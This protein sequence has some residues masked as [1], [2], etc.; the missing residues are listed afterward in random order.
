M[1][2]PLV[3]NN[4][5]ENTIED[6]LTEVSDSTAAAA[7]VE[8]QILMLIESMKQSLSQAGRPKFK[9]FWDARIQCVDLLKMPMGL[10]VRQGYWNEVTTLSKEARNLKQFFDRDVSF[11][12]DQIQ[13]AFQALEEQVESLSSSDRRLSLIGEHAPQYLLMEKDFFE[14]LQ[15]KLQH[16]QG[17]LSQVQALRKEILAS[18][19][20][21]KTKTS[22]LDRSSRLLDTLF[23]MKRDWTGQISNKYQEVVERFLSLYPRDASLPKATHEIKEEIKFLQSLGKLISITPDTFLKIREVLSQKWDE[24][25]EVENDIRESIAQRKTQFKAFVEEFSKQINEF[26]AFC[27]SDEATTTLVD[28]KHK[29]LFDQMKTKEIDRDTF[30]SLKNQLSKAR[31]PFDQKI[32]KHLDEQ[33]QEAQ[34]ADAQV[35]QKFH[36]IKTSFEDLLLK[37]Q[38]LPLE[39]LQDSFEKTKAEFAKN[40]FT[41]FHSQVLDHLSFQLHDVIQNAKDQRLLSFS[42]EDREAHQQLTQLH[43]EKLKQRTELKKQLETSRKSL[44]TSGLDF[45]KAMALREKIEIEKQSYD[46]LCEFIEQ[47]EEKL[48]DLQSK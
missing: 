12:I 28:Q 47:I 20:R 45:E 18:S 37:H 26:S 16:M 27:L 11:E 38:E 43:Q 19:I 31:D 2:T 8:A 21:A 6:N 35:K 15:S 33:R 41:S 5:D 25:K 4:G 42:P 34:R 22:M 23:T 1:D 13:L 32:Y 30:K 3:D 29:Q 10:G 7:P 48:S 40:K 36:E 9:E 39:H 24:L 14:V 44:G 17:M 46:R